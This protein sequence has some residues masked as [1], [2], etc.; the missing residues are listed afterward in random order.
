MVR[1]PYVVHACC[2]EPCHKQ[3]FTIVK[4]GVRKFGVFLASAYSLEVLLSSVTDCSING[5]DTMLIVLI[6]IISTLT[7]T[8]MAHFEVTNYNYR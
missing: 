1:G 8:E 3:F 5:F 6:K 7:E 4:L 2:I